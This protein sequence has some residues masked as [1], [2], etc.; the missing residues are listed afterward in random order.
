[1]NF[2]YLPFAGGLSV[3]A[4]LLALCVPHQIQLQVAF[5]FFGT[6]LTIPTC[7][8]SVSVIHLGQLILLPHP[9]VLVLYII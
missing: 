5:D 6:I 1:M 2:P 8:D 3:E 4:I 9:G 7:L